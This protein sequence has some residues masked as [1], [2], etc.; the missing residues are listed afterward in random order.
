M[1]A[2]GVRDRERGLRRRVGSALRCLIDVEGSGESRLDRER[3]L[4][5]RARTT[6]AEQ[7]RERQSTESATHLKRVGTRVDI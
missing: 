7:E 1:A 6:V 3:D 2:C 4:E 5:S